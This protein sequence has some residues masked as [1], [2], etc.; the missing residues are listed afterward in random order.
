[1]RRFEAQR[2]HRDF[3]PEAILY[4]VEH[5]PLC[6]SQQLAPQ[7]GHGHRY[8]CRRERLVDD[9]SPEG[10][11]GGLRG[12]RHSDG[13]EALERRGQHL[14]V[15]LLWHSERHLHTCVAATVTHAAA[16]RVAVT[17]I[18][19]GG[20][21]KSCRRSKAG[22]YGEQARFLSGHHV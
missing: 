4:E 8:E 17:G 15:L 18:R 1:M 12:C 10:K 13:E 9:C 3:Y 7:V 16:T 11:Q 6:R 14:V 22:A 19:G 2:R 21:S 20:K 5:A